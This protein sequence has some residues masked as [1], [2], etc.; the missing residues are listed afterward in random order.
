MSKKSIGWISHKDNNSVIYTDKGTEIKGF[1]HESM[2]GETI[3]PGSPVVINGTDQKTGSHYRIFA[4]VKKIETH[5]QY[6]YIES[7]GKGVQG[8]EMPIILEPYHE[9]TDKYNGPFQHLHSL[10]AAQIFFPDGEEYYEVLNLPKSGLPL[11]ILNEGGMNGNMLPYLY[12]ADKIYRSMVITG[13]QGVGKTI[14]LKYLSCV[15]ANKSGEKPATIILDVEQEFT[16]LNKL[17]PD[18]KAKKFLNKV[19]MG[20]KINSEVIAI[21]SSGPVGKVLD[22]SLLDPE[23]LLL[24]MPGLSEVTAPRMKIILEQVWKDFS[25]S[26]TP[27]GMKDIIDHATWKIDLGSI[28]NIQQSQ[29]VAMKNALNT[30]ELNVFDQ[31]GKPKLTLCN[32]LKASKT[33]VI[34]IHSLTD[35]ERRTVVLY[36]MIILAKYKMRTKRNKPDVLLV[37]DEAHEFFP[38]ENKSVFRK[39]YLK[40]VESFV[41]AIPHKG[42]KRSYGLI[43][44]TQHPADVSKMITDLCSTKVIF[45]MVEYT[46]ERWV[47]AQL[48]KGYS[49]K[50]KD[51]RDGEA[52]ITC[53]DIHPD[54]IPIYTPFLRSISG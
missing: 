28:A 21:E 16:N 44:A 47:N 29:K 51:L 50:V 40:R 32:L 43:F 2:R 25:A 4:R 33:T 20:C 37:I 3:Y 48:R 54:P 10:S 53:K 18:G 49:Q 1:L 42:R 12:D 14:F 24:M 41:K 34:D 27:F 52:Y 8:F 39:E 7:Q 15:Y 13:M 26:K 31:V 17:K 5:N 11:G 35:S 36:L 9:I 22:P 6:S 19:K 46:Q 38:A 30:L 45:R 23:D